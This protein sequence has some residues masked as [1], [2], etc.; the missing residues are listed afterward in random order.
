M[1]YQSSKI[2]DLINEKEKKDE[3]Y[4]S[5]EYFPP[6]TDQGIQNLYARLDRMAQYKPM[7][8]DVTWGAG[9]STSD[10]TPQI[11][12][13]ALKFCGL[14]PQMH[15]TCTNMERSKLDRALKEVKEAGMKNILALR[16][17][18]PRGEEW[19]AVEGGFAHA[20][21]L[22]AYI[23]KE[24]GDYFCIAVAGYPEKHVDAKSYEEDLVHLKTKVDAGAN[25]I[26]T[27]LFY[28]A[29]IFLKFVDDCHKIGINVPI[30]PGL[31]PIRSYSGLVRMCSLCGST[32]PKKIL[33]DLEPVK[34]DDAAVQEYGV[35]QCVEMCRE[36]IA[37]GV[38]GLHFYTLNM[39]VSVQKILL[40]LGL[41]N[42]THLRRELPWVGARN[43]PRNGRRTEAVRPI[44]WA[45]R[46][47]SFIARSGTW[48]EFPN[49]RWGDAESPAFDT[50]GNYHLSTL[51]ASSVQTRQTEW[52]SPASE[53]D[54]FEVFC[55]YLSGKISR[56]PW[57]DTQ[58]ATESNAII[59]QLKKL[60]AAG[61]LTIN[62]QPRVN[63]ASSEDPVSGWGP[64][65]GYVYQKAYI[66]FFASQDLLAKLIKLIP[67]YASLDYQ[68][69]NAKGQDMGSLKGVAAVTWGVWPGSE[70]K[71]PT[72]VD[73]KVFMD[74]WKDEAFGLW[75]TQWA[76]LYPE[77]STSRKVIEDIANNYYLVNIVDNDFINGN[78]FAIFNEVIDSL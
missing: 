29:K 42:E 44:F 20:S 28:D 61:F 56:L 74:I 18:P 33:E 52:G 13:D 3:V 70:I 77:G 6:K 2:I 51:Y 11:C 45:N 7:F 54:V 49:G 32:V 4:F 59:D 35:K 73:P 39:E 69:V 67:K 78:I 24:Y 57:N 43:S 5:F 19:K 8:I 17:D 1:S 48:D 66:E 10:L 64:V 14:E 36:L 72:V 30:L 9:G 41:I 34:D 47:K 55:K 26:I 40:E 25:L 71:Q 27:Q 16:G 60:N 37:N 76:S 31:M 75:Q 15:L 22:V 46:P 65:G 62:S 38:R 68:A 63:G 21:D 23:R 53:A 50:L 58:L 12:I